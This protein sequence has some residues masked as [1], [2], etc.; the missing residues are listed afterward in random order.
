MTLRGPI[1]KVFSRWSSPPASGWWGRPPRA[2]AVVLVHGATGTH[3]VRWPR[4]NRAVPHS[5]VSQT[6]GEVRVEGA[7]GLSVL[8]WKFPVIL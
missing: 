6:V 8:F 2:A 3:S 4:G 5:Y 7:W 1:G